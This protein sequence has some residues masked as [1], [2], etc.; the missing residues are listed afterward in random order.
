MA[1]RRAPER[2]FASGRRLVL[3]GLTEE[4]KEAVTWAR[5]EK[6]PGRC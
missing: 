5:R 4:L 1:L 3:S 6:K 2:F